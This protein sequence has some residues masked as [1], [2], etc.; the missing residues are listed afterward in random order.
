MGWI[1]SLVVSLVVSLIVA[2]SCCA[3]MASS[4]KHNPQPEEFYQV[5]Y[6]T[7]GVGENPKTC[8]LFRDRLGW[9]QAWRWYKVIGE[10]TKLPNGKYLFMWDDEGGQPWVVL[11]DH[12]TYTRTEH[13]VEMTDRNVLV[14]W[15]RRSGL[16]NKAEKLELERQREADAIGLDVKDLP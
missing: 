16:L 6:N 7:F 10:P 9:I 2:L 3:A 5:E 15:H 11:V 8:A 13:D 1:A 12:I 4:D 14:P